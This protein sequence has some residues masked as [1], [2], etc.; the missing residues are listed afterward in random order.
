MT[1]I[2]QRES[3][4]PSL[5]GATEWLNSEPLTAADLQ[6]RVVLV[7]FGTYTCI[8]WLR[9]LPHIRAWEER[10]R[11]AG[12]VVLGIQTPEFQ[13]EQNLDSVRREVAARGIGWPVAVDNRYEIWRAFS[14]RYWP[15]LYFVDR[16]GVIRDDHFGEG[17]YEQSERVIQQL[18]GLPPQDLVSVHGEGDEAAA[19]WTHLNTAETYLG[20]ERTDSFASPGGVGPGET[21]VFAA[22]ERLKLNHWALSG[23][24]TMRGDRIVL[25]EAGGRI[26][27]RF[28]SRDVHL[29][30]RQADGEKP[31]PFRVLLDGEAP[32]AAHGADVDVDGNGALDDDRLYQLVREPGPVEERTFT[33]AFQAPGV[34]A[35]VFTFG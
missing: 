7:D 1:T 25:N 20:Y 4:M 17:R 14:N 35:Y 12:L 24:W 6:G 10:Y 2:F 23:N 21:R 29:V 22:P 31:V 3:R 26:L 9:T 5:A 34:E 28:R 11:E 18:L 13:F 15:A 33:I 8:N 32:R 30:L 16:E 19:D 27:F